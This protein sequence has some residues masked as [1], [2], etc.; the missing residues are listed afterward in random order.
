MNRNNRYCRVVL[1]VVFVMLP[2]M[3]AWCQ[4]RS[5]MGTDFWFSFM[6][7]RIEAGMSV[8]I[9]GIRACTGTI[10]NPNTGWSEGFSVPAGS[11]VIVNID[12]SDCYNYQSGRIVGKGIHIT[13]TDTVSVYA[14]NFLP[15]SLSAE[16]TA[17]QSAE[18]TAHHDVSFILPTPSL[19]NDYIVQTFYF[20]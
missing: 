7:G 8:A 3:R 11:S 4:G 2:L 10:S 12:T 1:I 13:T 19:C 6:K 20:H 9:T 16:L 15:T 14:S 18:P 5:T 17:H